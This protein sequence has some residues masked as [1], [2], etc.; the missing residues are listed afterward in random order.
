VIQAVSFKV[1][2]ATMRRIERG[3]QTM[4]T[5]M[6]A[7]F[8]TAF[9]DWGE[10]WQGRMADRFRGSDGGLHTRTGALK[11]SLDHRVSGNSAA[12]LKLRL[13][14]AGP[15]YARI[16]ESG[17]VIRPVR[18]KFLAIPLEANKTAAGV[19]RYPSPR[20]FIAA[21]PGETFFLRT[22][23]GKLL[24]MWKSPTAAARKS[25]K[26]A[27]GEAVPLWLLVRQVDIPGPNSPGHQQA[28]RLGFFDTWRGMERERR[29]R[30][31]RIARSIGR[32]P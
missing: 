12:D 8:K 23:T 24:I 6:G 16:Q 15:S 10:A 26:A 9:R 31:A 17:G 19:A 25:G 29:V 7:E 11:R 14:S 28:S 22:Q 5:R 27:K 3:F 4:P 18:A 30:M 13:V 1:Q 32:F 20:E 21:H 2:E